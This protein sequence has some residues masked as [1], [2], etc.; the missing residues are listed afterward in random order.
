LRSF[1]ITAVAAV[2]ALC[3]HA[4]FAQAALPPVP[5]VPSTIGKASAVATPLH[6]CTMADPA[7]LKA[8]RTAA[9]KHP[10]LIAWNIA[11]TPP[12]IEQTVAIASADAKGCL[13]V[14]A[15]PAGGVDAMKLQVPYAVVDKAADWSA[16]YTA[17]VM[18]IRNDD[19][20]AGD[21]LPRLKRHVKLVTSLFESKG[22]D[23]YIVLA[24]EAHEWAYLHW[25]DEDTAKRAFATPE[26]ATGP[27]DSRSIQ[28]AV[29]Q[30]LLA[31]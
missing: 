27:R 1:P 29:R 20:P 10:V 22:M 12:H 4:S 25:T 18:N 3:S 7:P 23:G 26:G 8:A 24:G 21:Y 2:A 9:G 17:L 5:D 11:E 31:K 16:G 6:F 19:L 28:R 13:P 30:T 15:L 14:K